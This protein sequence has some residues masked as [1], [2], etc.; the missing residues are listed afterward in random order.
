MRRRSELWAALAVA[1]LTSC[2]PKER[3]A[4]APTERL[5]AEQEVLKV[6]SSW[7][8]L[9]EE[10]GTR[11]GNNKVAV[12]DVK[13]RSTLTLVK[14]NVEGSEKI[15]FKERFETRTGQVYECRATTTTHVRVRFGR[16]QGMPAVQVARP[17]VILRRSC[18]PT[19]FPDPEI[20]I[21]GG[22]SRFLL[23]DEQLVGFAP[24]SE[25]R[26]YLPKQ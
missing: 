6:S 21:V 17:S 5:T 13:T 24:P 10:H 9:E 26:V 18:Q 8:A 11:G 15:D 1:L 19:D 2:A 4:E 23:Q 20:Q 3:P 22:T 14:G 7:Q 16:R 12:Y 25:K